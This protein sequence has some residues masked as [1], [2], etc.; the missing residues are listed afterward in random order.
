MNDKNAFPIYY[1]LSISSNI[2]F[3]WMQVFIW[4]HFLSV[5]KT[6]LIMFLITG[7]LVTHFFIFRFSKKGLLFTVMFWQIFLLDIEIEVAS[8]FLP[9]LY[10]VLLSLG[11]PLLWQEVCCD[12]FLVPFACLQVVMH[13]PWAPSEHLWE[14]VFRFVQ[15]SI[16]S[17][18]P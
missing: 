14:R 4:Q 13:N 2:Y 3:L 15:S 10:V 11:L 17:V 9:G 5:W 8:S 7:L 6:I 1:I 18:P 12:S 16:V